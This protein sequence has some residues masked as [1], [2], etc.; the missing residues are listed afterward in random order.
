M[1]FCFGFGVSIALFWLV[2]FTRLFCRLVSG[3]DVRFI[4]VCYRFCR[5][6]ISY[7]LDLF[8][9]WFVWGCV[10]SL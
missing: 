3:F 10:V 2:L 8:C 1:L 7:M 5:V 9:I 4:V 6:R